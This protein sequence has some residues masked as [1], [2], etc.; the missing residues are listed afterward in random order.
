M[1]DGL[2]V[3]LFVGSL[4]GVEVGSTDGRAELLLDPNR[5]MNNKNICI[6]FQ[7]KTTVPL[8]NAM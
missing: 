3:G 8:R 7:E 2:F 4:E 5:N 6:C 1:I